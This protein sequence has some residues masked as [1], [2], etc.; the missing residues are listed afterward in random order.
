MG[1]FPEESPRRR[2]RFPRRHAAAGRRRFSPAA[3]EG[4]VA[5]TFER[6]GMLFH[7]PRP[8][9]PLG[10]AAVSEAHTE[11]LATRERRRRVRLPKEAMSEGGTPHGNSTT[12]AP[13]TE[14]PATVRSSLSE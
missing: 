3:A 5:V 7:A 4:L 14:R 11:T 8:S 1:R 12:P 6:R 10:N 2:R 9:P 13:A